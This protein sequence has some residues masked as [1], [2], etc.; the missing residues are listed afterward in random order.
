M[1][2]NSNIIGSA[3]HIYPDNINLSNDIILSFDLDILNS[4]YEQS[5]LAIYNLDDDIWSFCETYI[6]DNKLK[7]VCN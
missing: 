3:F 2:S 4:E 6:E 7:T 5:N 1:Y